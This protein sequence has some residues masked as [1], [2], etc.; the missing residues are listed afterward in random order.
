[1]QQVSSSNYLRRMPRD[2]PMDRGRGRR[3]RYRPTKL[4]RNLCSR[5]HLERATPR[6]LWEV[7]MAA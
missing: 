2:R 5:E 1:M 4:V 7:A 3:D 6:S